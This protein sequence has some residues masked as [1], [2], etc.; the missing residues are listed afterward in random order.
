L[1]LPLGLC[2]VML[3][4]FVLLSI[5]LT[6]DWH[7]IHED[8]GALHTTL[9]LSHLKLGLAKTRAHDVFFNP[10]TGEA[11]VYGHHPP[12]TALILA[13]AFKLTGS[14]SPPVARMVPIVFH[15]GSVC[16]LVVLLRGFFSTGTAVFGGFLMATLPMSA[17]FGRMVNYE[18]LCLFAIA[19]QLAG[20][21]AF[22]RSASKTAL[23]WLCFGIVLGG[24]IGWG[25]FFFAAAIVGLESTRALRRLPR[26]SELLAASAAAAAAVFVFDLWHFSYAAHGT[27]AAFREAFSHEP[28]KFTLVKFFGGQIDIFRRYFTHAGLVSGLIVVLCLVRPRLR[29]SKSVF[30]VTE[31]DLIRDLLVITGVA[32]GGNVLAAPTWAK[33]HMYWQFYFLPFVTLSMTLVWSSLWRKIAKTQSRA[34]QALAVI[35]ILEVIVTSAYMLHFRHTRPGSYAIEKTAELRATYLAPMHPGEKD[36]ETGGEQ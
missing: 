4:A 25:S 19:V 2:I 36:A 27:L 7:L 28:R 22:R 9:A 34:F 31:A 21:A 17:Y 8:N 1:S 11:A 14:D 32:A 12:L 29:L 35:F 24:L 33:V 13:G 30:G 23:A 16:L 15:L 18:P 10:S 3:Y 26:S 5:G 6:S 20:Y